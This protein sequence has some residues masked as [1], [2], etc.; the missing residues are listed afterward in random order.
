[1]TPV[2]SSPDTSRRS[3]IRRLGGGRAGGAALGAVAIALVAGLSA[4]PADGPLP[5]A[6]APS[7]TVFAAAP[8]LT[9]S[10]PV[11]QSYADLVDRVS[12]AVVT[13][14]ATRT[15]QR[16]S[17]QGAPDLFRRFFGE[18]FEGPRVPRREGGL[19]SGVVVTADG[20]ILTNNHVV[21]GA[22]RVS[23]D[24]TDGRNLSAKVVG[25]DPPSDLALLKVEGTKLPTL[26][27]ADSDQAR[28]GDVVLAIGNPLN[29]GQTVTMGI[30]SA[31]GRATSGDGFEDFIQTDA[32]INRG[33][34]GG[35]L[36][37]LRG[38]L[39]GINSQILSPSG[40]N[41][42]I[43]FA[44]PSSMAH[45]VM[46]QL[47]ETGKVRRGMLGVF[48]QGVDADLAR[49]LGL[50]AV[51][52]A[53]VSQVTPGGPAAKAGVQQGDVILSLNDRP[54]DSSNALKNAVARVAPGTAVRMK[55][56]RN[57]KEQTLDVTLGERE[58][59]RRTR[60]DRGEEGAEPAGGKYGIGVEP[61][62]PEL[63]RRLG[64]KAERGV[65]VSEIDPTGPA[66]ETPL[67]PG[68]VILQAN[69]QPVADADDLRAALDATAPDRPA[70]LLVSRRGDTV[71]MTIE[72]P[73]N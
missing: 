32:P 2:Q 8:A 37:N 63:A 9:Q 58:V 64:V 52:G 6:V 60:A 30:I 26:P 70:L 56:L 7:G 24:F 12:P 11:P 5:G 40:F 4:W 73:T 59:D 57:G 17:M 27:L 62:T 53:I 47:I 69:R 34:S 25:T 54:V 28:V 46:T 31:K 48:V 72:K 10:G 15:V 23:V 35:A 20:Y 42:G 22:E 45:N 29:L 36:V 50:S 71:F 43:G 61:L 21:E 33:N 1:M 68:D 14:R 18:E 16:T 55:L 41:I 67:Q 13:V 3:P 65:V 51:R 49:S 66:A 38:E 39:I 19:G 44:I